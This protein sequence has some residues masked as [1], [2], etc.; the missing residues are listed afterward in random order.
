[1]LEV[2][3]P[4]AA[5]LPGE[6]EIIPPRSS[7]A[8]AAFVVPT[9]PSSIDDA[10]P[11]TAQHCEA[12]PSEL[13]PPASVAPGSGTI[14]Y[15]HLAFD[16]SLVPGS[17]QIFNNHVPLDLDLDESITITKT[18]PTVTVVRGQLVPYVITI[19]NG[20]AVNLT[21]VTVVDRF[22]AGFR[23]V[24][25][26]ARLDGEPREPVLA[27]RE[28]AWTGLDV[29][30]DGRHTLQLLLAVGSGVGE[31]DFV[32]RAQAMGAR[33]GRVMSSEATATVRIVPD[34]ALDCTDVY[35]KVFDD[36]NR[37]GLQDDG[38][39]GIPG[40]RVATA[41]GLLAMTDQF[42]RFHI[43]CA[44]TPHEGRGTNF[45]LKLDDRTLPSGFRASTQNLQIQRATRGKALEFNFGASIHRVIGLDLADPVFEPGSIEI[46]PLWLPRLELLMTELRT[47]PA[48]L[49]LS[50]L[51]D[52]E[53]PQLVDARLKVLR[54]QIEEAWAN[55]E[56]GPSYELAIEPDVFWRRGEPTEA[57]ERRKG[58]RE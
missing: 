24:E 39:G 42:G 18:T 28:L 22:P 20:I 51:A 46:R 23:Y 25:G 14:Y 29:T 32:N 13:Q 7:A 2:S 17:S 30:P 31:G 54:G 48:V 9:C 27:G 43:T 3:P 49:R 8:T 45:V 35:G 44:I 33:T 38:E 55:T 6:S 16:S 57:R 21:D 36:A 41:R 12:T 56:G 11:A 58:D 47:G 53:D 5:Y 37:N 1:L 19:A 10:V 4:S 40:A 15:R 26:S 50:Y 34:P 52:L